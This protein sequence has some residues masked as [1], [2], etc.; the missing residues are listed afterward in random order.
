MLPFNPQD[1]ELITASLKKRKG[2]LLIIFG[3]RRA[4]KVELIQQCVDKN[5]IYF[6]ADQQESPLQI[7]AFKVE[8]NRSIPSLTWSNE[9]DWL[10]IFSSISAHGKEKFTLIIDEFPN[11]L[12]NDSELLH[13]L[14]QII[15]AGH[16]KNINIILCG[17]SL[18]AMRQLSEPLSPL[19][20][21]ID[22]SLE[23]KEQGLGALKDYLDLDASSALEEYGIW[24]GMPDY[25]KM[26]KQQDSFAVAVKN[27][28]LD[29]LGM[30]HEEAERLFLDEMRSS[31][32]TYSIMS[33][34]ATENYRLS[35]I[36]VKLGKPPTQLTRI[37]SNLIDLGY[38]RREIPFGESALN[39]KRSLYKIDNP[40]LHFYFGF[41]VPNRSRLGLG[42]IDKVWSD[43]SFRLP[44]YTA[45]NWEDLSRKAISQLE[46]GGKPWAAAS[47][48]WGK[49]I[50]GKSMEIG[51]VADSKDKKSILFG[52]AKWS[53]NLAIDEAIR[54]LDQKISNFPATDNKEVVKVLFVREKPLKSH[55]GAILLSPEDLP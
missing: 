9:N 47:R 28:I 51:I 39:S 1:L 42:M 16:L 23:I 12:K 18:Q 19:Y 31:V 24:G 13:V 4:G 2:Q 20:K 8:L 43:I 37:L 32:Q 38:I 49:G 44:M 10:S 48:W 5:T 50:D 14:E 3:P 40:F 33:L 53:R 11:L 27:L 17:S 15:D 36:A 21:C 34:L 25:W 6:K 55:P 29:P 26:R 41:V 46:I 30:L 54:A 22:L 35:Q 52:E 45:L 7:A